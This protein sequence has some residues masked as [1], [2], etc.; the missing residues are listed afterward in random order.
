M[1]NLKAELSRSGLG[2]IYSL[3]AFRGL[4]VILM[5]LVNNPGSW[6]YI[7]SPLRHPPWHGLSLADLVFPFFL[8][9]VGMSLPL[10]IQRRMQ[11]GETNREIIRH[12]VFRSFWILFW[13]L[14]LNAFPYFEWE[15]LRIPGVLQRI[16]IVYLVS[17]LLYRFLSLPVQIFFLVLILTLYTLVTLWVPAIDRPG[18]DDFSYSPD[19]HFGAGLD[20]FLFGN[21]LWQVTQTY[22]PEGLFSTI[23]CLAN[24]LSG[25]WWSKY[26]L[27]ERKAPGLFRFS[28][29][30]SRILFLFGL[31]LSGLVASF[32]L[33]VNKTLWTPA[34]ALSTSS[35]GLL[36]VFVLSVFE[37]STRRF[38]SWTL[39][40]GTHA[41]FVFVFTG[42]LSRILVL[43]LESMHG[44]S[45]KS[46]LWNWIFGIFDPY[47]GSFLY[48]ICYFFFSW[49]ILKVTIS[50]KSKIQK[51]FWN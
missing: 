29:L 3:D 11:K 26:F 21:H 32:F 27:E 43:P 37:K 8:V 12:V 7:Y 24:S 38:L 14:V 18:G 50:I 13:G 4:T 30:D 48:S 23:P 28:F 51:P 10:A 17:F 47:L 44:L 16:G 46:A 49:A 15:G 2:R 9:A 25:I 22:D 41:L 6:T 34:F 19:N 45:L 20:R 35:L 31:A 5:I 42:L 1:G 40:F 36:F 39:P 33:P